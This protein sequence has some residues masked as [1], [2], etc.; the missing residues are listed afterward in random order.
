MGFWKEVVE[1]NKKMR[2]NAKR[3]KIETPKIKAKLGTK[4]LPPFLSVHNLEKW[5]ALPEHT[6]CLLALHYENLSI[7][8]YEKNLEILLPYEKIID[9]E[10][11]TS[12]S[13]TYKKK[14]KSVIGRGIIGGALF[15]GAGA[16][17]GAMS[18]LKDN[19][20]EIKESKKIS[21]LGIK[22]NT[23]EGESAVVFK[24]EDWGARMVEKAIRKM[25]NLD[26]IEKNEA[27]NETGNEQTPNMP[28]GTIKL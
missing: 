3:R 21:Y 24:T 11:E 13:I 27:N 1:D 6:H 9:T 14:N 23:N 15:G 7:S 4:S 20:K 2:E 26:P 8:V 28:T 10:V 25:A 19:T 16:V 5:E 22:Y 17:V 18:G 12:E